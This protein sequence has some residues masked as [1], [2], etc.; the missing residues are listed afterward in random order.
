MMT[1]KIT[2]II[3]TSLLG[4]A[5]SGP[6]SAAAG[7]DS[8]LG[9][10]V[11][12]QRSQNA[13]I[14]YCT[15]VLEGRN[16]KPAD[17]A[18]AHLRRGIALSHRGRTLEAIDDFTRA[19]ADNPSLQPAWA[20]RGSARM[21]LGAASE[22]VADYDEAIRL[23][24]QDAR[25][26]HNR[27]VALRA[28]GQTERAI[29][30]YGKAI[31]LDAFNAES[32]L[33][34]GVA[35]QAVEEHRR[36]VGDFNAALRIA[37]QLASAY[38]NRG[39]SYRAMGLDE[40]AVDDFE[41]ALRIDPGYVRALVNRGAMRR[42]RGDMAAALADFDRAVT[43]NPAFADAFFN[44]GLLHFSERRYRQAV[45]DF[46]RAAAVGAGRMALLWQY[47]AHSR[48]T[49]TN[50]EDTLLATPAT[51][52]TWPA[53]IAAY[54]AGRSS[55]SDLFERA[56][57]GTDYQ[58]RA[59][60]CEALFYVAEKKLLQQDP[61][62]AARLFGSAMEACPKDFLEYELAAAELSH[63]GASIHGDLDQPRRK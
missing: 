7:E 54:L 55:Q 40:R 32:F 44:R 8:A 5:F 37:P 2:R 30:D 22:A 26:F 10:C 21:R 27:A 6:A 28:L 18:L 47:L 25:T 53:Q 36:A 45:V 48:A 29:E 59:Q 46:A 52:A 38:S 23:D 16:L 24:S 58:Q 9:Q 63:L 3:A 4:A 20:A 31:R 62:E 35:W 19:V 33:G 13:A 17:R 56:Q 1:M 50:A 39:V 61:S 15:Q 34:R 60:R 14:D 41:A 12:A 11:R 57:R 43:L 51:E 49:G 42:A